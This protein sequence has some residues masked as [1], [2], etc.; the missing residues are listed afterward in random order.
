[1]KSPSS[2]LACLNCG[3]DESEAVLLSIRFRGA[4]RWIC[5]QCFPMLIHNRGRLAGRLEGAETPTPAQREDE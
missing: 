4:T 5:N 3:K 1:M 2:E